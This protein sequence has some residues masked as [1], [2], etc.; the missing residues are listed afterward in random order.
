[1]SHEILDK[2]KL[3]IPSPN[4]SNNLGAER[5]K[6][7]PNPNALS[8]TDMENYFKV[9]IALGIVFKSNEIINLNQPSLFFKF[10][11]GKDLAQ[12]ENLTFL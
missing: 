12:L 9:G 4:N 3:F 8:Y 11:L 6:V 7:V 1:M 10:L 2:L 5:E